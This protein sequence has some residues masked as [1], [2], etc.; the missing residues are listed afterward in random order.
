MGCFDARTACMTDTTM[1][2]NKFIQCPILP[3]EIVFHPSWWNKHAGICFDQDFFYHPLKRVESEQQMEKVLYERFGQYGLGQDHDKKLPQIGAVHNAAGYL[4]SE[5][6][7]CE[8]RYA[9]NSAPQVLPAH[10]E[11]LELDV[12]AA[13]E[14]PAFRRMETLLAELKK[15]HGYLCGDIN[16]SGVLNLAMDLR[17]EDILMDMFMQAEELKVYFKKIASVIE[18][19]FNYIQQQTGSNSI[20]VNRNVR[21]VAQG[22]Y[23]HSECSHTMISAEQ[24]EEFLWPIDADWNR[25]YRPFGIHYC[26]PDPQR[27]VEQMSRLPQLDFLD[28][29]WGGDIACLRQHLPHTFINLRLDPV[30]I[31]NVSCDELSAHIRRLVKDSANPYLTGICCINMDDKTDDAKIACIFETVAELRKAYK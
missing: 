2:Q 23:L 3:V 16:W 21:N 8:I 26:G 18:R 28:A 25:K 1:N 11:S 24:Y 9:E 13:F 4:L 22:L 27:H 20:S 31:N 17:G 14:S 15:S 12:D 10:R 19:F 6:L 7:G 30:S 5:M 29:G